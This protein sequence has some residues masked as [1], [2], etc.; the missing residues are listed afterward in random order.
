MHDQDDFHTRLLFWRQLVFSLTYGRD[1]NI[2]FLP[3]YVLMYILIWNNHA[4]CTI[5]YSVVKIAKTIKNEK[6]NIV[7]V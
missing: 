7:S 1:I 2:I 5:Y 6:T 3:Y 4:Y